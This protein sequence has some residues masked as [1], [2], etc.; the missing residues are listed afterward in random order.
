M[1]K[2][3]QN[4]LPGFIYNEQLP[5]LTELDPIDPSLLSILEIGDHFSVAKSLQG[6]IKITEEPTME[7]QFTGMSR[8]N[9]QFLFGLKS[10]PET[11]SSIKLGPK[12][13]SPNNMSTRHATP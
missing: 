3:G 11:P 13:F 5:L 12:I 10:P 2:I 4:D 9:K 8:Q 6:L 7:S 1:L